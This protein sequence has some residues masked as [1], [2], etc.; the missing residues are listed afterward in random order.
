MVNYRNK[1]MFLK[2]I[3]LLLI[4]LEDGHL[5]EEIPQT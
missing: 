1:V 5:E 4:L 3:L 2:I